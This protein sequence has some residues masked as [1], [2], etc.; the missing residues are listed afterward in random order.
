MSE[1]A[2]E[3]IL[4]L[5]GESGVFDYMMLAEKFEDIDE[6]MVKKFINERVRKDRRE[7]R[8]V[9]EAATEEEMQ[10][11]VAVELLPEEEFEKL[12]KM[13]VTGDYILPGIHNIRNVFARLYFLTDDDK[14][15]LYGEWT[16]KPKNIIKLE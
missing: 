9:L 15:A 5:P 12:R 3:N 7:V 13:A 14:Y 10:T 11:F 16:K 2:A 6:A 4:D 8:E 1:N